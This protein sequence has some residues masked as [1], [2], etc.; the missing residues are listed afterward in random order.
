MLSPGSQTFNHPRE[1]SNCSRSKSSKMTCLIKDLLSH[2]NWD[3]RHLYNVNQMYRLTLLKKNQRW[4]LISHTC[5]HQSK[6]KLSTQTL[7]EMRSMD[8][9]PL[10]QSANRDN[11]SIWLKGQNPKCIRK[12]KETEL[13]QITQSKMTKL[14]KLFKAVTWGHK[15]WGLWWS[16]KE[17]MDQN[18]SNLWLSKTLSKNH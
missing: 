5:F 17:I 13:L 12:E 8:F 15:S 11:S 6:T 7:K 1:E 16:R 10:S 2:R 18:W 9:L 3:K 14:T 4:S